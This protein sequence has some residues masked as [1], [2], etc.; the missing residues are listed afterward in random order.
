MVTVVVSCGVVRVGF[1]WCQEQSVGKVV[2]MAKLVKVTIA[3][4]GVKLRKL[5]KLHAIDVSN[6]QVVN[7]YF[8]KGAR[9]ALRKRIVKK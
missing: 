1:S 4:D 9:S 8:W 2:F 3:V 7:Y 6:A 5:V